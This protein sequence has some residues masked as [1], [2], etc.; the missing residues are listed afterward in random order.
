MIMEWFISVFWYEHSTTAQITLYRME[1]RESGLS[2]NFKW[3]R[4]CLWAVF[5]TFIFIFIFVFVDC[6]IRFYFSSLSFYF[7]LHCY[8]LAFVNHSVLVSSLHIIEM[9]NTGEFEW[10]RA[11][12]WAHVSHPI[13]SMIQV[14]LRCCLLERLTLDAWQIVTWHCRDANLK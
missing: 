11:N 7:V 9:E 13:K 5:F 1:V 12:K 14:L 6:I 10:M 2:T 4:I 8:S 3:R